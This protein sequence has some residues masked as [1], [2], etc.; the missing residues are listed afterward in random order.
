MTSDADDSGQTDPQVVRKSSSGPPDSAAAASGSD[1]LGDAKKQ[2]QA[3]PSLQDLNATE[4]QEQPNAE[5]AA[6]KEDV[7]QNA[8][9]VNQFFGATYN[10]AATY[11]ASRRQSRP[12]GRDR[13]TGEINRAEVLHIT[14]RYIEPLMF[15]EARQA[16]AAKGLV[17]IIG[18]PEVGKTAAALALHASQDRQKQATPI[19]RL[20]PALQMAELAAYPFSPDTQYILIDKLRDSVD[21]SEYDFNTQNLL[22]SLSATGA[23]LVL[24]SSS[25]IEFSGIG[26]LRASLFS[27]WTLPPTEKT[28]AAALALMENPPDQDA[29]SRL[30]QHIQGL[31]EA[32]DI[33]DLL[34]RLPVGGIHS[35]IEGSSSKRREKVR[36]WMDEIDKS[37]DP[38][39]SRMVCA[40]AIAAFAPAL[41]LSIFDRVSEYLMSS[42]EAEH[43]DETVA[44]SPKLRQVRRRVFGSESLVELAQKPGSVDGDY[45]QVAQLRSG[46]DPD[47]VLAELCDRYDLT[48]WTPLHSWV[49]GVAESQDDF[50]MTQ[51]AIGV[52]GLWKWDPSGI[53]NRFI[54]R[55]AASSDSGQVTMASLSMWAICD[56]ETYSSAALDIVVRWALYGSRSEK[57]TALG[58]FSGLLGL[59]FPEEAIR[60]LWYFAADDPSETYAGEATGALVALIA[61]ATLEETGGGAVLALVSGALDRSRQRLTTNSNRARAEFRHAS[62][63]RAIV[64]ATLVRPFRPLP[65]ACLHSSTD[66]VRPLA[67]MFAEG[68]RSLRHRTDVVLALARTLSAIAIYDEKSLSVAKLGEEITSRLTQR[69]LRALERDLTDAL[70]NYDR[71]PRKIVE[72]VLEQLTRI[73]SMK[74]SGK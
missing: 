26:R 35:A 37:A 9:V 69:E 46:I 36:S 25:G 33:Q 15:P 18:Q 32:S 30:E 53:R 43:S 58:A 2:G 27:D 55:W 72:A 7:A 17:V 41:P 51:V 56:D 4:R 34:E 29:L 16:L 70:N 54:D 12:I 49:D 44:A 57:V 21:E 40:A 38:V 67:E 42:F 28:V 62:V 5:K 48:F 65:V 24:T 31:V 13:V 47:V 64:S 61:M 63:A 14:S 60:W 50:M 68:F 19:I 71:L 45:Q 74:E 52:A 20:N 59:V 6:P 39:S 3:S 8:R 11:G 10:S 66:S 73:F 1:A 23:Q 22:D